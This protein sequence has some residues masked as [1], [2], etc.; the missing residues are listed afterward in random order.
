MAPL[1][2][3]QKAKPNPLLNPP[4][5]DAALDRLE[6]EEAKIGAFIMLKTSEVFRNFGGLVDIIGVV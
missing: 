4:S 5:F 1:L 6:R 2:T 3:R